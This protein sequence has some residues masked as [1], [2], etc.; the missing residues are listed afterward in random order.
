[1]VDCALVIPARLDSRRFPRKLVYPVLERPLV[2][3]TAEAAYRAAD[4][5]PLYFAAGDSEIACL[6]EEAGYQVLMTEPDLPSGTDRL[7]A[8]NRE[9]RAEILI[10]IQ[11]DEPMV[12]PRQVRE[13]RELAEEGRFDIA[14]L[15]RPFTGID[16]F[17]DPNNVKVLLGEDRR[18]LYFTRAPVPYP[19][20]DKGQHT[21]AL[22][23]EAPVRHHLGLY[24]YRRE[25]LQRFSGLKPGRLEMIERLE[26]LRAL[27]HGYTI[28]VGETIDPTVGVDTREDVPRLE[29][30]LRSLRAN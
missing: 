8:A 13:L 21:P 6:L 11:A 5:I 9:I 17:H 15:A 27:E 4:G 10:N 20:D 7:A 23:R 18:A 24:A 25:F 3:W 22:L 19:R 12:T 29:A 16:A 30:A 26:Q 14:T 2:L 28:G 1:M